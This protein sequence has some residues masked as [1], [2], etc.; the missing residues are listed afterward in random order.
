[1]VHVVTHI[2]SGSVDVVTGE[3]DAVPPVELDV[4]VPERAARQIV[5][6]TEAPAELD[7]GRVQ[8]RYSSRSEG[9]E[10]VGRSSA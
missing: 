6:R 7:V 8:C 1:V 3:R 9:S 10:S 2:V 5:Q 4:R